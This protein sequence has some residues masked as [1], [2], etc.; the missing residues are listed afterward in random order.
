MIGRPETTRATR[1]DVPIIDAYPPLKSPS[2]FLHEDKA[3]VA[4][5]EVSGHVV[6]KKFADRTVNDSF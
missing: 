3:P 5:V 6:E 2:V 1:G 4:T